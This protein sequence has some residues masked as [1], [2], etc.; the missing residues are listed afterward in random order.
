MKTLKVVL[1][2]ILMVLTSI[3]FSQSEERPLT[4]EL[5]NPEISKVIPIHMAVINRGLLKAMRQQLT[6]EF[7]LPDKQRYT[8]S[9]KYNSATYYISGRYE[10]WKSFFRE[11][12]VP[13]QIKNR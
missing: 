8:V 10:E 1:V 4:K 3:G 5:P 11:V 2:S 13:N 12:P 6:P 7:L 9:V